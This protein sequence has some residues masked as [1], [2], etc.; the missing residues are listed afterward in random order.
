MAT[1]ARSSQ[2]W[3]IQEGVRDAPHHHEPIAFIRRRGGG[4]E[5]IEAYYEK[6]FSEDAARRLAEMGYNYLETCYFKGLG[7]EAEQEEIQRTAKFIRACHRHGIRVGVYTQWGSLFNE[8]FFLEVPEA[9]SWVQ[10]GVDGKPI[11]YLDRVNQYFRWRGCPG[12]PDFL[13]YIKKAV[14]KAIAELKADVIYFDNLCLFE[15]HDTLCYCE[16]CRKGFREY[17][18]RRFPTAEAA[19]KRFGLRRLDGV[20]LPPLRPWTDH[21]ASAVP[22]KDPMVQE[23]IEFRCEQLADAWRQI[24]EYLRKLNPKAGLMANPSFPRKYNERLTGA[25]DFWL[26][27]DVPALHY[28]ENAV[29]NIG[30]REGVVVSNIR[31]YRYGRALGVTFLPC[32]RSDLPALTFA[33]CL[34]F[35][36]GTG[37]LDH[38]GFEPYLEFFRKHRDVFYRKVEPAA[39][40]AILRHDRSL[41]LRWHEA[42]TVMELAQQMLLTAGV[43]WMPIWGQQLTDGTLKKYRALVVPG[44]A[45]LSFEEVQAIARFAAGGGGVVLCENAGTFNEFHQTIRT[46][47]FAPLFEGADP[48]RFAMRYAERGAVPRFEHK[49]GPLRGEYGEGRVMYLPRIRATDEPVRTYEQIGGYDSFM[50]LSLP[51]RWR[52]LPE[53]VQWVA[54]GPLSV[55]IRARFTVLGEVLRKQRGRRLL[56][57]L[58]NYADKP[59]AAGTTIC[60]ADGEGREASLFRP[61]GNVKGRPLKATQSK[62]GRTCFRLPG[63]SRYALVVIE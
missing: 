62:D 38:A 7:L 40:V 17:L 26:L 34:A 22:I 15:Y 35:N 36:N 42:Y 29:R 41:T 5:D 37:T 56:V 25:V 9:R 1:R 52:T 33:E 18:A 2:P 12:N 61:S 23:F 27:K 11:E 63:F 60:L 13:A 32:G 8:T 10:I 55:Q 30:V 20:G 6:E 24:H 21:T 46:W 49:G 54:G 50:H 57:H 14:K 53:A 16:H 47:R 58:V 3:W 45:C 28:M 31:G 51:G 39:E 44:S 59:A 4:A 48:E 19:W 43:P